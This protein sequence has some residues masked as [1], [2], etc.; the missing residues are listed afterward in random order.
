MAST[1]AT[2]E[3]RLSRSQVNRGLSP[4]SL[5]LAGVFG[6]LFFAPLAFGATESWSI[7]VLEA[8]TALLF[9]L[10]VWRQS[11][12]GD[13]RLRENPLFAPMSLF[14]ALVIVQLVFG[15]TAYR[16]D[17]FSQALLY[18]TYG[19]L[20]FLAIQSL[21]RSS[22]ARAL[23]V[24][25]TVYGIAVASFALLQGLS[26]NGK[27]YWL[28]TPRMGGAIYGPYVSHNNYAGLM[29]M[30]VPIPLTFCLTRYAEGHLRTA[31]AAGAALMA[32]TIFLSGSRGGMISFV[33][34]MI[35]FA[36]VLIRM[37][38]GPR[39][40]ASA[41]IFAVVTI[42]LLMW[43]G[44]VELTK[45]VG[46]IGSETKQELSGGLRWTIDRDGLRMFAHK[47][48]LGWGLGTFPVAYPQFRSFYT[49]FFIN[50]AHN[51]YLQFLVETGAAGFALVLWFVVAVYRNALQKLRDWPDDIS[52]AVTLACLLGCTGI[53]VHSLVDFNLQIP[54]NAAWFY[55]F[56]AIAASPY[57][58]E[59]RQR[60]RRVRSLQ[61]RHPEAVAPGAP[62]PG[63]R[64]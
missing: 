1:L 22:Q 46:T 38:K 26:P 30:L 57:G 61:P 7:F 2:S 10:W 27:L 60:V 19:L 12:D 29:E 8:C 14:G 37:Q 52:G 33:A 54:A 13:W 44:G 17:T 24:A 62:E 50:D 23:A 45:R 64:L 16:H 40:A 9:A 35:F 15:W 49:T 28:R 3:P 32:G 39:V 42:A 5:L 41:G 58:L 20:P 4:D 31:V 56:S 63:P 43:I 18:L 55:V 6:L 34:E 36:V 51:D 59:S 21:R 11:A 48:I 47:P 25:I 53:L